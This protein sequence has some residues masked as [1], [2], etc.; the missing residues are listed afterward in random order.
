MRHRIFFGLLVVIVGVGFSTVHARTITTFDNRIVW[1]AASVRPGTELLTV[2]FNSLAEQT[3]AVPDGGAPGS[4]PRV[5]V[6]PF[7]LQGFGTPTGLP[8]DVDIIDAPP[9]QA[10]GAF[11]INGSTYALIKVAFGE[12]S[13]TSEIVIVGFDRPITAFG[14]DF[15]DA[16]AGAM[17]DLLL[18]PGDPSATRVPVTVN[19]GFF[20]FVSD[21][22]IELMHFTAR[23]EGG[24]IFGLDNVSI[25]AL[26]EG[27]STF[28]FILLG[29]ALV[30]SVLWRC[31]TGLVSEEVRDAESNPV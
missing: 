23:T 31:G 24:E 2:N 1:E 21:S 10:G 16:G 29:G 14:A 30:L 8:L 15:K 22:P 6:G 5:D 27:G 18:F 4:A 17:V 25:R 12:S 7:F 19:T 26:P 28:T 9:L 13:G 11:Q 3:F 20:G